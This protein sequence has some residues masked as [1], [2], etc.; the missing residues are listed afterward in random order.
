MPTEVDERPRVYLDK[1]H[2]KGFKSIEDL[3]IDFQKGLNILI[4]KN[5][6]GKSNFLD[7]IH[8]AVHT[9][10]NSKIL[11]KYANLRFLSEDNHTF[12]LE[13]EK[14]TYNR[15][16]KE[17]IP[18]AINVFERLIID[19]QTLLDTTNESDS[20]TAFLYYGRKIFYRKLTRLFINLGYQNIYPLYIKFNLPNKLTC[21][22]IPG[23]LRIGLENEFYY[24]IYP[25]TLPFIS[26]IFWKVES[27]Y[28][29][30]D[31]D[32]I[33]KISV[34]A[35]NEHLIF[36]Q[37][38]VTSLKKFTPIEDVKF[39]TNLNVYKDEKSVTIENIKLEFLINGN[40]LP[41]SQLS[42]GTRRLFFI[43][44]EVIYATGF[45]LIEEPELGIHPHQFHLLLNFLKE[46][47]EDK[48]IILSTHS[49]KAL[50]HL[51]ENELG[52][53][54]IAE[55]DLGKGTQIRHLT[56][57]ETDKAK[58]YIKEVGFFSDY[59]LMSDLEQW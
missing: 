41:W 40:W 27:S 28:D 57:E 32:T 21:I 30:D 3:T 17:S 9:D 13:L 49:P 26:E 39:N 11:F 58:E 45:V 7:F 38:I 42:D 56:D 47:S 23:T 44:S 48:Q 6:S 8:Q 31:I 22:D 5:G 50:D 35:I 25:D 51:N 16:D 14:A 19:N 43:V 34:P 4:G 10:A 52:N 59:W 15:I 24:W 18:D 20:R 36:N 37:D 53:I 55:Y 1:V 2:L 46:Q 29:V 33:S 54:L 12:V